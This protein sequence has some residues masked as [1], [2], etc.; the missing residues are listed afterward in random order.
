MK[1]TIENLMN[2]IEVKFTSLEEAGYFPQKT[3]DYKSFYEYLNNKYKRVLSKVGGRLSF[4]ESN[5]LSKYT[6]ELE[7]DILPHVKNLKSLSDLLFNMKKIESN[8][9]IEVDKVFKVL[10]SFINLND[11]LNPDETEKV[12][13]RLI[14]F[15]YN[16][17]AEETFK[18]STDRIINKLNDISD[19]KHNFVFKINQLYLKNMNIMSSDPARVTYNNRLDKKDFIKLVKA[20]GLTYHEKKQEPTGFKKFAETYSKPNVSC[21]EFREKMRLNPLPKNDVENLALRIHDITHVDFSK[22]DSFKEKIIFR[23]FKNVNLSYTSAIVIPKTIHNKH[24]FSLEGANLEGVDMRGIDLTKVKINK[25][26]LAK[27]GADITGAIGKC[28]Y[29]S[30]FVEPN[31][32]FVTNS[33]ISPEEF[34]KITKQN[35]LPINRHDIHAEFRKNRILRLYDIKCIDYS[36]INY[37]LDDYYRGNA[38]NKQPIENFTLDLSYTNADI[39]PQNYR[40]YN[41]PILINLEGVDMRN[42]DF[43]GVERIFSM[44]NLK[45]TGAKIDHGINPTASEY[46]DSSPKAI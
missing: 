19:E 23:P 14:E 6:F 28:I 11:K 18:L 1:Q 38:I 4:A 35:A 43:T 36:K 15:L 24:P 34:E 29:V 22:R 33:K 9:T 27:T 3:Q 5:A 39:N 21:L 44:A 8:D 41:S 30:A 25:A 17:I 42:K 16:M 32:I 7:K 10:N 12:Y 31:K 40:N 46:I 13:T 20:R 26:N 45:G 2:I 37:N